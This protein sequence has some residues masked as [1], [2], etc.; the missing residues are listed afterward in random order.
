MSRRDVPAAALKTE[1]VA[2][3]VGGHAAWIVDSDAQRVVLL[4]QKQNAVALLIAAASSTAVVVQKQTAV[5]VAL[6]I[7]VAVAL[8]PAVLQAASVVAHPLAEALA[9][10]IEASVA[11]R[12]ALELT[13]DTEV[14]RETVLVD[15]WLTGANVV[16]LSAALVERKTVVQGA[17]TVA[18]QTAEA[19]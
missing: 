4:V 17:V 2:F 18:S 5:S 3:G 13:F 9:K 6:Q 15:A 16:Q 1:S 14:V 19:V 7:I 10:Q 8:K 11:R 12:V